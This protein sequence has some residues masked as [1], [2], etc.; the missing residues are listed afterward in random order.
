MGIAVAAGSIEELV[1]EITDHRGLLTTLTGCKFEL[2]DDA[3]TFIFGNGTYAGAVAATA[4]G[5]SV[6]ANV[7]H[8]GLTP[9]QYALYVWFQDGSQTVRRG[10]YWYTVT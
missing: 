9:G 3:G 2:T 6:V 10:P 7:D 1:V 4:Q 8:T 5:M